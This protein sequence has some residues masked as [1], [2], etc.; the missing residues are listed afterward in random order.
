MIQLKEIKPLFPLIHLV[1]MFLPI[2]QSPGKKKTIT[3]ILHLLFDFSH[4]IYRKQ[5]LSKLKT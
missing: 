3:L 1:P 2:V 4:F 5:F